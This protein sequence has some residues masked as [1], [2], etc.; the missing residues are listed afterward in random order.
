M[1]QAVPK[2]PAAA[3]HPAGTWFSPE[4]GAAVSFGEVLDHAS[5]MS[6]VLLGETHDRPEIHRWQLQVATALHARGRPIALGFEI[7]PRRLQPVLDRWVAGE[8]DTETFLVECEWFD[9]WGFDPELYLPLL[10]S[11]RQQ[12]LPMLALNCYR[13]LVTRVRIEGWAAIPESERDG[14]TPAKRRTDA[15]RDHLRRLMGGMRGAAPGIADADFEGFIAAQQTWDRAFAENIAKALRRPDAPL[16]IGIIGR[17]HLEF[18]HG[19]PYQLRD[20]GIDDVAVL[21]PHSGV[22]SSPWSLDKGIADA[23]FHIDEPEP[24]PPLPARYGFGITVEREALVITAVDADTPA[25]AAG[26]SAG[27]RIMTIAGRPAAT[28]PAL[29]GILRRVAPGTVLPITVARGATP[30]ECLVRVP[31]TPPPRR[32]RPGERPPWPR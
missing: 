19:T 17:G 13:A 22:E 1:Q 26:L 12:R 15:Y 16:V 10:Q 3:N 11:C 6:A 25:A 20:L 18:G 23:V 32:L 7:F 21:L 5:R 8:F 4:R 9:V 14:L 31:L 29:T 30:V 27:D 28:K 24:P 2:P